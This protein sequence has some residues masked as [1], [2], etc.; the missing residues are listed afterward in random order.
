[1]V[2]SA[3]EHKHSSCEKILL[4]NPHLIHISVGAAVTWRSQVTKLNNV[5]SNI[6]PVPKALKNIYE[7]NTL[8]V[9]C[10]KLRKRCHSDGLPHQV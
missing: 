7:K 6:S 2:F 10:V 5:S 8:Y 4:T 1:M 9:L 3:Q